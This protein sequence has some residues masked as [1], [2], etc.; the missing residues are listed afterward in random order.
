[1]GLAVA[2]LPPLAAGSALA[3]NP[4]AT[5]A[6][7]GSDAGPGAGEA[8]D[9]GAPVAPAG[10]ALGDAGAP[11]LTMLAGPLPTFRPHAPPLPP[12]TAEQLAAYSALQEETDAYQRGAKDYRDSITT[13]VTLHYEEKKKSILG[14]LDRE[15]AIEKEELR[16]ARD[17]A[18]RRLEDFIAK[19]SGGNA[20]PEATPDA[21]YRLAALYE[22]RARSDDDPNADLALTLKPAIALYKRVIHQ[23][24]GYHQLAGIYYFLG[25]A[26]ND[27]RRAGEAQ[28]VW[29]SV[30][31]H[32]HYPYPTTTDPKDSDIDQV[33]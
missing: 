8:A 18:I 22:E 15:V 26:L 21:M 31:C 3:A 14:S 33:T 12:P 17:S 11:A 10:G 25:H 27:S 32:N 23:F 19:Y 24:P 7:V 4:L 30:V 5:A 28:Q 2:A 13:I 9:S 20:Q 1:M 29:R 6:P 16:K